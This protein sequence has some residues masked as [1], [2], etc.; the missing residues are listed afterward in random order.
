MFAIKYL[1]N[2]KHLWHWNAFDENLKIN[3]WSRGYITCSQSK[4]MLP[5]K[6]NDEKLT[7]TNFDC[8]N[9]VACLL[10][11][12]GLIRAKDDKKT[13]RWHYYS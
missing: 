13:R 3:K 4:Q 12:L 9:C 11:L 10:L 7:I 2:L 5:D 8:K 6:H 1:P